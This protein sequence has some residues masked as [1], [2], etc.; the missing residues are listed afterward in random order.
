MKI[1]D[2][3]RWYGIRKPAWIASTRWKEQCI[4]D[5][6]DVDFISNN[7]FDTKQEYGLVTRLDT[8]T[9]GYLRCAKTPAHKQRYLA[10]QK[11]NTITKIYHARVHGDITTQ[12]ITALMAHHRDHNMIVLSKDT[13]KH[14]R[15]KI[16]QATTHIKNIWY[17]DDMSD[18]IIAIS[19]WARH[20]IRCHCAYVWHPI[21][22]DDIYGTDIWPLQLTSIGIR[23][24]TWEYI[25]WWYS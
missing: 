11:A 8:P 3:W 5:D 14:M 13:A 23:R 22:W 6:L 10:Q 19:Q 2:I 16:I 17:A 4:L 18:C 12:V 20:Q 7:H 15:G 25:E 9:S 21:V 24:D 1:V